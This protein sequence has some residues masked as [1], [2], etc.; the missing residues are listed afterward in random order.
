MRSRGPSGARRWLES[1]VRFVG[2]AIAVV[3]AD[4]LAQAEDAAEAVVGDYDPLPAGDRPGDGARTRRPRACGP[5]TARTWSPRS[6]RAWDDDVLAG[7]DVVARG[8]FVNQR[9][10][11]VPMEGNAIAVQPHGDGIVHGVGL[12]P[13]AVRRP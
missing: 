13:S 11:P 3:V 1:V 12:D 8:R 6:R 10:A 5:S 4:T 7:A 2:E 9:V